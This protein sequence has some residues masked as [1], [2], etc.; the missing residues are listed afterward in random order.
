MLLK[1]LATM[2]LL[3]PATLVIGHGAFETAAEIAFHEAHHQKAKRSIESCSQRLHKRDAVE[4]R[5]ANTDA[6]ID[7]HRRSQAIDQHHSSTALKRDFIIN[8]L[9]STCILTPEAEEGP[10]YVDGML[11]RQDIRE[12]QPG[13]DLLLDIQI[14]NVNTCKPMPGVYVDFWNANGTG[15]YSGKEVEGTAGLTYLRGLQA[16]D[17]NG[18]AQVLTSFP[19]FYSGRAQHVHVKAHVNG[20]VAEN[21]TFVGGSVVHTGQLF[22]AQSTL[23]VVNTI[24]PYTEDPNDIT[25][26]SVDQVIQGQANTTY[27]NAVAETRSLGYNISAGLIGFI[28]IAIDPTTI[29]EA[30]GRGSGSGGS[31]GGDANGTMPSGSMPSGGMAS[32]GISSGS[33]GGA[34][35]AV[36]SA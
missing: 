35:P 14:T 17:S 2:S 4:K 31:M 18:I 3:L 24:F 36:T 8:G 33:A 7:S 30:A 22:F 15:V 16:S 5:F 13:I 27:Y 20:T 9:N 19:G 29:P 32:G 34:P 11:I 10:F 1:F 21:N 12:S 23:D 26:N 28:N 6:F 25:L